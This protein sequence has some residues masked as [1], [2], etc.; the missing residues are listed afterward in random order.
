MIA[1]MTLDVADALSLIAEGACGR[2]E[3]PVA[4]ILAIIFAGRGQRRRREGHRAE[5]RSALGH[6]FYQGVG[7]RVDDKQ[8]DGTRVRDINS[9][10]LWRDRY[11]RLRVTGLDSI[12][13]GVGGRIYDRY[14]CAAEI[15]DIRAG[16]VGR[17]RY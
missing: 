11:F 16:S 8:A 3:P 17:D 5:T 12:N 15:R 14:V 1:R 2:A 13:H 7:G 9:R 6:R 4:A 10:A